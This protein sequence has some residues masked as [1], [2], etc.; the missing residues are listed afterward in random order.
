MNIKMLLS[1]KIKITM[2]QISFIELTTTL[3]S[4]QKELF[5]VI[6][7]MVSVLERMITNDAEKLKTN[8]WMQKIL[9][10][11]ELFKETTK[12][13]FENRELIIE[14]SQDQVTYDR[15]YTITFLKGNTPQFVASLTLFDIRNITSESKNFSEFLIIKNDSMETFEIFFEKLALFCFKTS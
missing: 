3:T 13:T 4:T 14:F 2:K 11:P 10:L 15:N 8:I 6:Y 1:L 7:K 9:I 12:I 5:I